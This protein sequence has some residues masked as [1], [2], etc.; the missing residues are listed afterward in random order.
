MEKDLQK[1]NRRIE[2][3]KQRL[4]R[5]GL[6]RVQ[7]S[8]ILLLTALAGFLTSYSLLHA[9]ISL[10]TLRYPVAILIAYCVFLLL[11]RLWIWLQKN[12]LDV[13]LAGLDLSGSSG[14]SSGS[15]AEFKFG[16]GGDFGGGGAGGS[17]GKSLL[18]SSSSSDSSI[19]DN[20]SFDSDSEGLGLLILAAVAIIGGM[21]ASLYIIYI[22][23]ILLAEVLVDGVL[24]AGL[25]KRVKNIEQRHWLKTAVNRTIVPAVLVAALFTLAGF[26]M[27]K[28]VPE[29]RSIGEVWNYIKAE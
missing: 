3:V 20:V 1:R 16:G 26:A 13:D 6:P 19:L 29:A 4:L 28:A 18:L 14:S 2:F 15:D 10:M 12:S 11:L 7:I 8:I 17:W 24:V 23:P 5:K 25:Y 27:Q 21:L 9:G 22:A